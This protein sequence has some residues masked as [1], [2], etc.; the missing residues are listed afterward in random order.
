M[1]DSG[2][3]RGYWNE[4]LMTR[5]AQGATSLIGGPQS[6]LI[7]LLRS[8]HSQGR[9]TPGT[10]IQQLLKMKVKHKREAPNAEIFKLESKI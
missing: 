6:L 3:L 8:K 7:L 1:P 10:V 2:F 4:F 9:K 5:R